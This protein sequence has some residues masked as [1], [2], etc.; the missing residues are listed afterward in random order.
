MQ[1]E[2]RKKG[3]N[4]GCFIFIAL[5]I[6]AFIYLPW[7][8]AL[9]A[10]FFFSI[11]MVLFFSITNEIRKIIRRNTTRKTLISQAKEGYTELEVKL[12][13]ERADLRTWIGNEP[14]DFHWVSFQRFHGSKST[15]TRGNWISFFDL[16]S[17]TNAFKVADGSGT[18]WVGTHMADFRVEMNINYYDAG[19]L[20][21]K[22]GKTPISNFPLADLGDHRDLRVV[23]HW[24]PKGQ[25]IF[26]YGYMHDLRNGFEPIME[27]TNRAYGSDEYRINRQRLLSEEQWT[28]LMTKSES[29]SPR[30]TKILTSNYA[31]EPAEGVIISKSG[32]KVVNTKSYLALLAFSV[33]LLLI[34]YI[35][36]GPFLQEFPKIKDQILDWLTH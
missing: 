13:P 21:Q 1:I 4:I 32:D 27:A 23:E 6:L 19:E 9:G 35:V 28:E 5:A 26:L 10:L 34:L 20:R 31:A 11:A 29:A 36:L 24:I 30:I 12:R 2:K 17:E 8:L 25:S 15:E 7:F 14:A 3:S 18:C 33:G 22:L 16:Q